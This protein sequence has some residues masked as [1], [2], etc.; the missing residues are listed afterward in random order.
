MEKRFVGVTRFSVVSTKNSGFRLS[1]TDR[2]DYLGKLFDDDRLRSR[3]DIFENFS[4]RSLRHFANKYN[5]VHLV[6]VSPELPD[7][8]KKKLDQ[9]S[10]SNPFLK[11]VTVKDEDM[12]DTVKAEIASW[13]RDFEGLFSWF[14]LDDD[15][16]LSFDYLDELNYLT[17]EE[18]VGYAIS[19][20]RVL[21]ACHL[22]GTFTNVH[23][24]LSPHIAI[25]Q[26]FVGYANNR[27]GITACPKQ[28]PH[29]IVNQ[30]Y[31]TII[32]DLVPFGFWTRHPSQDSHVGSPRIGAL[33][34]NL[35][36][37]LARHPLATEAEIKDKFPQLWEVVAPS[38]LPPET[39]NLQ[40]RISTE[41]TEWMDNPFLDWPVR[42]ERLLRCD[43]VINFS[44]KPQSGTTLQLD[45]KDKQRVDGQFPRDDARGDYRR[46]FVDAAGRGSIILPIDIENLSR[47]RFKPDNG[48]SPFNRVELTFT[49]LR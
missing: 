32:N 11:I 4:L 26:A 38:N 34:S 10:A 33:L 23:K 41:Q 36:A 49:L 31:P 22:E 12:S 9:L 42:D 30:F 48:T 21:S 16:L 29:H 2:E 47:I 18:H 35:Q 39:Q 14:R 8:W 25:G 19:F 43:Y 44:G 3:V 45:F 15:D 46:L 40:A 37:D 28:V 20:G 7:K 13:G 17:T 27:K 24:V 5:F 1:T 6:Q